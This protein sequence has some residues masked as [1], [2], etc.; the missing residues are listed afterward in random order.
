[1]AIGIKAELL[2]DITYK[3]AKARYLDDPRFVWQEKWDGDRRLI[4]K[5]DDCVQD[6]NRNGEPGKGLSPEVVRALR[7]HPLKKFIIDVEFV[8]AFNMVVVFDFLQ[9]G[10]TLLVGHPYSVRLSLLEKAF[11]CGDP[12]V[13]PIET[14][15]TAEEKM[16]LA[17]RLFAEDAEGFVIKDMDAPYRPR[18]GGR[19]WNWR[20]KFWKTLDAVVIGDSTSRD[21][22]GMLKDSV[23]V[24]CY[25]PDGA[26]KD[27]CGV[28]KKTR[29]PVG[30]GDVVEVKYLYGS[31]TL[32]IVQPTILRQRFDKAPSEC[33]LSQVVVSK[34]FKGRMR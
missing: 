9:V 8:S 19:R 21:D 34:K 3:L 27:I 2:Q 18:E 31:D 28:T 25:G 4:T 13:V 7:A 10:D 6:F 17:R 30:P 26:L 16:A 12:H 5:D 15:R 23:R 24:G 29:V 14:A 20:C 33:L 11:P 22:N 32:D 1:M